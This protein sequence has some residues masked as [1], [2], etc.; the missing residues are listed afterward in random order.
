MDELRIVCWGVDWCRGYS[1][2]CGKRG[3]SR[4]ITQ[5]NVYERCIEY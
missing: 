5:M 3:L 2:C 4:A 1:L